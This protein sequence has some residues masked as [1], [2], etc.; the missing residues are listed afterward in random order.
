M[1][2]NI[3]LGFLVALMMLP[4]FVFAG[5]N[6]VLSQP[7]VMKWILGITGTGLL[8]SIGLVFKLRNAIKQISEFATVFKKYIDKQAESAELK[9]VKTEA[10]EALESIAD[11]LDSVKLKKQADGLRKLL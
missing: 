10:D 9:A 11:V 1:V 4:V 3:A 6:E 7:N 8:G 2:R 5:T